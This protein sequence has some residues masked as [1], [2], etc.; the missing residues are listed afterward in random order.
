MTNHTD[1]EYLDEVTTLSKSLE[2][3]VLEWTGERMVPEKCDWDTILDHVFRYKFA[4]PFAKGKDVLDIACGEGYG[5]NCLAR[6]GARSV[7]GVDID[8][9]AV[10][11]AQIKYGIEARVGSA[12]SIPAGDDQ[13]DLIVSFETIEHVADPGLFLDECVRVCRPGGALVVSTPNKAVYLHDAHPNDFHLSEME[14]GEFL[15]LLEKRFSSVELYGQCIT[16]ASWLSLSN[17][18]VATGSPWFKV[19]GMRRLRSW[20]QRMLDPEIFRDDNSSNGLD[21]VMLV[22][23]KTGYAVDCFNP[24]LVRAVN[25][26][27]EKPCYLI[28]VAKL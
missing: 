1:P 9:E 5:S 2:V 20:L 18:C 4:I 3:K 15:E 6:F 11:H 21:P 14:A 7:V 19:P 12:E 28:A 22:G 24:H 17:C 23:R 27:L 16:S 26:E 10:T 8:G 25:V 13:F